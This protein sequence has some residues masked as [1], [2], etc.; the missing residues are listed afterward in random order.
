MAVQVRSRAEGKSGGFAWIKDADLKA[1]AESR[2][3][4]AGLMKPPAA[5][6]TTDYELD[7]LVLDARLPAFSGAASADVEVAWTLV[8][9]QDKEVLFR[10]IIA[11]QH[12]GGRLDAVTAASRG[13]MAVEAAAGKNIDILVKELGALNF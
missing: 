12:T 1:T 4:A 5:G 6:A 9:S 11:S 7:A 8:R 2:L 10:K 13:R 3:Q